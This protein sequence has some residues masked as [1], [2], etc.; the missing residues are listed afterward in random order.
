MILKTQYGTKVEFLSF[1]DD[2]MI[3]INHFGYS[4]EMLIDDL[5]E[6]SKRILEETKKKLTKT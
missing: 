1:H 6:E 2:K 4:L 5:C 3:T